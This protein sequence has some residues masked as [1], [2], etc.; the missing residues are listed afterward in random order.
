VLGDL[1]E[2]TRLDYTLIGSAVNHA[3]R[4]S[5]GADRGEV[6]ISESV[7]D[8]LTERS[9]QRISKLRTSDT[10]SIKIKP[11]DPELEAI[12][13]RVVQYGT[14]GTAGI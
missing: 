12:R 5:D 6:L 3:S 10:I 1:G 8:G 9:L 2:K 13:L 14:A 4:L 11:Y 7:L